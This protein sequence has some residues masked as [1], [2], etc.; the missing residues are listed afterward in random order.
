[1][2]TGA[3][4]FSSSRPRFAKAF[5]VV[6]V[7]DWPIA[8]AMVSDETTSIRPNSEDCPTCALKCAW[9]VFIVRSVNQ[10]LS[11]SVTVRPSGCWYTSPIWK[12]S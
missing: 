3:V 9:L 10:E 11:V 6:S 8:M 12:S 2:K 5:W 1:M 4:S 7:T